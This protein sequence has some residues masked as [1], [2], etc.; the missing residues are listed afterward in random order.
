MIIM[1]MIIMIMIIVMGALGI[2]PT[3]TAQIQKTLL[4]GTAGILE[5]VLEI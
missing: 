1:L 2:V 4:L 5:R 3:M